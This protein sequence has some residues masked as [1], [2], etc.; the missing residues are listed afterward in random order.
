MIITSDA[1]EKGHSTLGT[2]RRILHSTRLLFRLDNR[3]LNASKSSD[4][5]QA[6]VSQLSTQIWQP[7]LSTMM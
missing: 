3:F 4:I 1:D 6:D 2:S 5:H 7:H